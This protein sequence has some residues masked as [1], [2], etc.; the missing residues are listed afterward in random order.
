MPLDVDP[1]EQSAILDGPHGTW[2]KGKCRLCLGS[3]L[4]SNRLYSNL[5]P[6]LYTLRPF[7]T[8]SSLFIPFRRPSLAHNSKDLAQP[9]H[10]AFKG[11]W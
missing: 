7:P 10:L 3:W 5:S 11:L 9:H 8:P 2:T 4:P 6:R 1:F